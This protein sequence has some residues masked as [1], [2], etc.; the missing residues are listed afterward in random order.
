MVIFGPTDLSLRKA[1]NSQTLV[2]DATGFKNLTVSFKIQGIGSVD[3]GC[4]SGGFSDC[5]QL[6][7]NADPVVG[8]PGLDIPTSETPFGPY[9]LA[10]AD[11]TFD[12]TF[13]IDVTGFDEKAD[14]LTI[15]VKGDAI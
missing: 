4:G 14:F 2:V 11:T 6:W 5:W 9:A 8:L 13:V 7:E 1:A 10:S 15:T 12:L 3:A